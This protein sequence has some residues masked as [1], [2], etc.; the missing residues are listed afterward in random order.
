MHEAKRQSDFVCGIRRVKERG[1]ED[2]RVVCATCDGGGT[3][4]HDTREQA[5]SAAVRDSN[6]PC[7]CR[8]ACGA[9]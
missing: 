4:R 5:T 7:P 8:Q 9:K 3:I 6:K 2:F 1:P